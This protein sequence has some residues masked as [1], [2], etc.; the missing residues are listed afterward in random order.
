[1]YD[2]PLAV[3][4]SQRVLQALLTS[5]DRR[6]SISRE[7]SP[8]GTSAYGRLIVAIAL[9]RLGFQDQAL[10]LSSVANDLLTELRGDPVH[11]V[12]TSIFSARLEQA[13][14]GM[15]RASALPM[16]VIGDMERL[17]RSSR[18]WVDSLR[19]QS[20]TLASDVI[21]N[22][23]ERFARHG[24]VAEIARPPKHLS[25]GR[26]L[27][28]PSKFPSVDHQQLLHYLGHSITLQEDIAI[29]LIASSL[30]SILEAQNILLSSR[31]LSVSA[32]FGYGEL[33]APLAQSI[34]E[35]IQSSE[36]S[37]ETMSPIIRSLAKL[38]MHDELRIILDRIDQLSTSSLEVRMLVAGGVAHFAPLEAQ[39]RF[40]AQVAQLSTPLNRRDTGNVR[41]IC[42]GIAHA[43]F[44]F[45]AQT[46]SNFSSSVAAVED[47]ERANRWYSRTAIHLLESFVLCI[48]DLA[49]CEGAR[50]GKTDYAL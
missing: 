10:V 15:P 11:A 2:E 49:E 34:Q 32:E 35:S 23:I 8:E 39:Q 40:G 9:A 44:E 50:M 48:T 27:D 17:D 19:E 42:S 24:L 41:S 30:Q 45:G 26:E 47:S 36:A 25:A 7:I 14:C 12:L 5:F 4:H 6:I 1:M 46:I 28:L 20:P 13:I 29:P 33:A 31:A 18:F 38:G 3:A 22:P 43:P 16:L 37:P 21:P